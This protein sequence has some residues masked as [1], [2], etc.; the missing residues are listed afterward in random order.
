MWEQ[1][2]NPVIIVNH[3]PVKILHVDGILFP[4][5]IHPPT[6]V[7]RFGWWA[8]RSRTEGSLLLTNQEEMLVL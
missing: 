3:T 4:I 2:L 5:P 1:K 6:K 7:D 8:P